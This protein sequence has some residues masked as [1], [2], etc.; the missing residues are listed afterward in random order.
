MDDLN[1]IASRYVL[2]FL[3]PEEMVQLADQALNE[4]HC[5]LSWFFMAIQ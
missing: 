2:G 1:V 3:R 4:D 5:D